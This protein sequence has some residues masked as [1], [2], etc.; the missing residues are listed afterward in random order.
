MYQLITTTLYSITEPV[1]VFK[2]PIKIKK[3]RCP[4]S[5]T[6]NHKTVTA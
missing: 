1:V 2:I 4:I 3:K 6:P 5:L